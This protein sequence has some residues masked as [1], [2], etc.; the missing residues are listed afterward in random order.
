MKKKITLLTATI[1]LLATVGTGFSAEFLYAPNDGVGNP[2]DLKD[3]DHSYAYK[4]EINL[5]AGDLYGNVIDTSKIIGADLIFYDLYNWDDNYNI[6]HVSALNPNDTTGTYSPEST[7]TV[8]SGNNQGKV[9]VYNDRGGDTDTVDYF[10]TYGFTGA[11]LLFQ[12]ENLDNVDRYENNPLIVAL[13][14]SSSTEEITIDDNQDYYDYSYFGDDA[15]LT[16]KANTLGKLTSYISGNILTL[17][18]D[19]DC[20]FYN[21]GIKL[22]LY[23]DDTPP[24]TP[25]DAV[26]EPGTLLLFGIGL[27]GISSFS[28]KR[29][30]TG[31]DKIS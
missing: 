11:E 19:P 21:N 23:T 20:H 26:P 1:L 27:M 17:G 15:L 4:W 2:Y 25:G 29:M 10:A 14:K 9:S 28:R 22:K 24:G 16:M 30:T 3:L 5:G 13:N 31:E 7:Y 6:L 8:N 12:I 18:F